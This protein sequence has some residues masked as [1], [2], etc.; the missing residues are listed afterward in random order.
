M[1]ELI[2][3]AIV[4]VHFAFVIYVVIG[5]FL[6]L[7]WPRTILLHIVAVGWAA[8]NGFLGV[9]CPLTELERVTRRAGGMPP[10]PD[11]GFISHY[12]T[13]VFYPRGAATAV[14]LGTFAVIVIS[15]VLYA[16]MRRRAHLVARSRP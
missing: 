13:G 2:L 12:I 14:Q 1:Y 4:A 9:P 11:S 10:L 15:W 7:R 6:A 3:A 16:A 5:G 8:A